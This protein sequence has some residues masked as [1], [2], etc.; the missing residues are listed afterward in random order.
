MATVYKAVDLTSQRPVA[1]KVLFPQLSSD[2]IT[3]TRFLREARAGMELDHP[4]IVKVYEVG[5]EKKQSFIA[6]ELVEGKTLYEMIREEPLDM[7]RVIDIGLE[8][9]DALAAA[10]ERGIIHR[11]IKPQNVMV[12]NGTVK[13][14]D[15][16][17]VRMMDASTLTE[18]YE[19]VGTL[20]Y[21]SP[22]QAIGAQIDERSDIFS[23]GVVLYQLLTGT[24]PFEGD[25][26]GAIIHSILHSDPLRME[27]LRKGIPV[28]VEQVVFKAIQK[29]PQ[30][31]YQS[32]V[33]FK[34]DLERVREILK[35]KPHTLIATEEVFEERARGIYSAL[36]GRERELEILEGHL[37]RMLK[38]EGSM[39]LVRGE[40][41]IGKSRLVWELGRKAKREKARYFLGRCVFGKEGLPYQPILEVI[42]S[43]LELKG[44][45][46]TGRLHDFI[47]EKVPHLTDRMGV[48]QTFLFMKGEKGS[49]LINKEQL[50]DTATELVKVMSQDKPILL[51]L[52]D[53]HWA[54]LPTLNLLTYLSRNTRGERVLIVGTYRPEELVEE[55]EEKPH[56]LLS[57]L[58]RMGREGLYKEINLERLD[59]E[60]TQSVIHSVFPHSDF[61]ESFAH[62]IYEETEGNPL[63]ILEVLKLLRDEGVISQEDRGWSPSGDVGKVDIPGRVNDVIMNRLGRL[64]REERTLVDVASVEGRSFQSDTICHC[65][66]LPRMKVLLS[67]QDL[68]QS[69]HLIHASEREYH[70]DHGKI[71]EV[72]Y[73]NLI[74]EL[75]REYH[76]LLGEYFTKNFGEKEKYAGKIAHHL[77]EADEEKEALPYLLRAGEHAKNLFANEEAIGYFDKGIEL[78]DKYL[79]QHPTP[80]LQRT[81][82]TQLKGRV[83]VKA[84]LG[85]YDDAREDYKS[86]ENLAKG[87]G[88][89]KEQAYGLNGF[90]AT[91]R[92]KGDYELS[93][94]YYEQALIIQRQI[95]DKLGESSTLIGI[96]HVHESRGDYELSLKYYEQ[97]LG[98]KR[99]IEDKLGESSTLIGIGNVHWNHGDYELSLNYY[100]RALRIRRELEDKLGESNTLFGIGNVHWNR[101]D[102]ELS[103]N[104]YEQAL[105]I[106][107]QIGDKRGESDTLI[108]IG[109]VHVDRGDYEL[110]LSSYEQCLRIKRQIGDKRRESIVLDNIGFIHW[111]HGDYKLSLSYN[112][113]ALRIQRQIRDKDSEGNTLHNIGLIHWNRGDYELS[114]SCLEQA[115][116]IVRQIGNKQ[117]QW[118]SQH[119]LC[120][121][122]WDM[123]DTEK[124]LEKLEEARRIAQAIGTRKMSVRSQ[125]DTGLAKFL[126]G[127]YEDAHLDI[128]KGL[129]IAREMKEIDAIIEGLVVAARIEIVRGNGLKASQYAEEALSLAMD[130]GRK[131]DIAQAHLLLACIHLSKRDLQD[132]ESYASQAQKISESCGMKE[133]LRQAYYYLGKVYYKKKQYSLAQEELRKAEEVV[134]KIL[135]NLGEELRKIYI[136]K[137]ETKEIYKNLKIIKKSKSKGR[138][139]S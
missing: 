11:D 132:A 15:F 9:A 87:L 75:K 51:H 23:L 39:I 36:A 53:L 92:R 123:G 63:F 33:E 34:S 97:A 112:E 29:K 119:Y 73:D 41:G 126:R 64:N 54:D 40:A 60:R 79:E 80:D 26:P 100:E 5:E 110:A 58:K 104:Y 133:L 68:E 115:L 17:L 117:S 83:E 32:A 130:K 89:R 131:F 95:G 128:Q 19:I 88:D 125:I 139:K 46:D 10:H 12:S 136:A 91:S 50:W 27:E 2:E 3:R 8:I 28:E 13:V 69:H 93:L 25:H 65:L 49:S 61:P 45:R 72:A 37:E 38:G 30:E 57:A 90:G 127:F 14:M 4:G 22:Q 137:T 111:N 129:K 121:L 56:P 18:K 71:R 76:R 103:L 78:I 81:K 108:G 21:M 113:Q 47:R 98:I 94:N 86:I 67:L 62:L 135:S 138:R 74:P 84:L 109:N 82:L 105:R 102:Y 43:Y 85:R 16:G 55:P 24:L 66:G 99:Q 118:E 120:K 77:L 42:R 52:D 122:W 116:R 35:G 96:G 101:G 7:E 107:R 48:I 124:S 31:R 6:M 59:E 70:F 1:L 20:S 106:K 114:L 134:N 44:V